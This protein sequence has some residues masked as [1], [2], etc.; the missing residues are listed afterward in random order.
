MA[1]LESPLF[2]L[3]DALP[4]TPPNPHLLPQTRGITA[5]SADTVNM[6]SLPGGLR[7][8]G[9]TRRIGPVC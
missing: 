2:S 8:T 4:Q 1:R 9:V 6:V 5:S 3:A 7:V